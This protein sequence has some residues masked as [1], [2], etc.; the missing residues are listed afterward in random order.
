[1]IKTKWLIYTVIIGLIPFFIRTFIV[2][3]DKKWDIV[4]W[5][6]PVDFITFGL[7]LNLTNINELEDKDFEDKIWKTRN[8]GLSIIQII[9]FSSIFAILTYSEFKKNTDLNLVTVKTCSIVLAF[10]TFLFSYSI[11]NRLNVLAK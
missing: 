4:Y 9:I 10:V 6:N 2:F 5:L 7:V 3:F 1:M 11:Y 8:I